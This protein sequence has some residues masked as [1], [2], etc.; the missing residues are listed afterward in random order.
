[1]KK[2]LK[3]Q[4]STD[5]LFI[6][7]ELKTKANNHVVFSASGT[8]YNSL[9]WF[10][11]NY[12]ISGG[13]NLD[14]IPEFIKTVKDK[15]NIKKLQTI[16]D[17]WK[18]YHLNDMHADCEHAI[19][20][21]NSKDVSIYEYSFKGN[22]YKLKKLI[23]LIQKNS[24][25]SKSIKINNKIKQLINY[26][27]SFTSEFK[28]KHFPKVVQKFYKLSKSKT[29]NTQWLSYNAQLTPSGILC[30]PCPIC[31]YKYGTSWNYRPIP[32]DILQKITQLCK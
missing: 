16:H 14:I 15:R 12:L 29:V 22:F 21:T 32:S 28:L 8:L 4:N 31:G 5:T 13:Q 6:D 3:F 30:K 1:M 7:I 26:G 18:H 2:R 24:L 20:E 27:Y 10:N 25:L 19:N 11:D 17:I 9:T 23:T